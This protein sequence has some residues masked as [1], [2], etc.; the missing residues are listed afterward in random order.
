MTR[1]EF[2]QQATEAA[3]A[4]SSTSGFPAGITVAQ[5]ALESAYG[6]SRLSQQ[7]NNY[8]GIKAYGHREKV[9]MP[10]FEVEGGVRKRVTAQFARFGSMA[11]CFAARDALIASS[12]HFAE[13]RACRDDLERFLKALAHRW[14]TDPDYAAKV[15]AIY[16]RFDLHLLDANAKAALADKEKV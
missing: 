1:K 8:F 15:W 16:R 13:A 3:R 11:D 12:P 4:A 6:Q 2:L 5:A 14:A 10:T 9:V 7:A